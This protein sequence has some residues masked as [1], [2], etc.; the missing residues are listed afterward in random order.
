MILILRVISQLGCTT[1]TKVTN[2]LKA[3][4]IDNDPVL[5]CRAVRG[6][7]FSCPE[8]LGDVLLKKGTQKVAHFAHKPPTDCIF[9]TGET[10][11]HLKA[12]QMFLD[13]FQDSGLSAVPEFRFDWMDATRRADIAVRLAKGQF[14]AIE[15]QHTPIDPSELFARSR[16]YMAHGI[17]VHWVP[18]FDIGKLDTW[19][20]PLGLQVERYAARPFE[21]WIQAFNFGEIWLLDTR[22]EKIWKGNL[23][24][25]LIEQPARSWFEKGG[26]ERSAPGYS[27]PSKRWRTLDLCGPLELSMLKFSMAR[28][29]AAQIGP[30]QLPGGPTLKIDIKR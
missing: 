8:C 27:K 18:L 3:Y 1:P 24:P 14:A 5:A 20:P 9:G 19:A 11:A 2:M 6:H 7:S 16:D 30:Y 10:G 15:I 17:A 29:S 28:R 26:V 12:K 21:K 23:S 25:C 13:L 4:D 22:R